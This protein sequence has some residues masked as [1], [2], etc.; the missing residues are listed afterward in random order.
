MTG[1]VDWGG[2][3]GSSFDVSFDAPAAPL[4]GPDRS[5]WTGH[6]SRL[7][8]ARPAGASELIIERRD[9]TAEVIKCDGG[10]AYAE[11]VAQFEAV[12]S[13]RQAPVFGRTESLRLAKILDQLHLQTGG[14]LS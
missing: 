5:A 9:G 2:G 12:A 8:R 6:R 13:G 7:A 3:F 11:M 10:Y 1:W 4:D 14:V